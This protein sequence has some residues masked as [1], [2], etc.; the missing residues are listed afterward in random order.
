M[1]VEIEAKIKVDDLAPTRA[2]LQEAG[3]KFVADQFE[4]NAIFDTD[5]RSLLAADK[6]LRVRLAKDVK[7][8]EQSV[9][10]TFK[11]PRKHGPLKSRQ[12]N[13]L[14]ADDFDAAVELLEALNF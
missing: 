3:A 11:G 6:G 14:K 1:A 12:E 13:E 2:K 8:N 7:T 10:L 5:D 4:I 9:T